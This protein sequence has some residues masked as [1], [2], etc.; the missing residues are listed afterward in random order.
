M[1]KIPSKY[2]IVISEDQLEYNKDAKI[3]KIPLRMFL[4]I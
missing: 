2:G 3:I 1:K 4:L